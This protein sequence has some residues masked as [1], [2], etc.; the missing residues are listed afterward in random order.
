MLREE[1]DCL[2]LKQWPMDGRNSSSGKRFWFFFTPALPVAVLRMAISFISAKR[3]EG[4]ERTSERILFRQIRSKGM[5]KSR[6]RSV[7]VIVAMIQHGAAAGGGR[8]VF[9]L[10]SGPSLTSLLCS[11]KGLNGA[12]YTT[13]PPP[14]Q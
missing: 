10:L 7:R 12:D 8:R 6:R 13:P 3:A 5:K 4:V 1:K 14:P 11:R 2:V 9:P